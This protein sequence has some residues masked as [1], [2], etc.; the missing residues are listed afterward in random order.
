MSYKSESYYDKQFLLTTQN[1]PRNN[2]V[3]EWLIGNDLL[4]INRIIW[5][6]VHLGNLAQS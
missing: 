4:I 6:P 5:T 3:Y 2:F 1:V